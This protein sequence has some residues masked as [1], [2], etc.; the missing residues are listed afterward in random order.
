MMR[1]CAIYSAGPSLR[2]TL[3]PGLSETYETV[4]G[5]NFGAIYATQM[6]ERVDWLCAIDL[7]LID[8]QALLFG[9]QLMPMTGILTGQKGTA[10]YQDGIHHLPLDVDLVFAEALSNRSQH[11]RVVYSV[12]WALILAESLGYQHVDCYG[13][14]QSGDRYAIGDA[15]PTTTWEKQRRIMREVADRQ[16]ANGFTHALI[17]PPSSEDMP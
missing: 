7:Q 17:H 4:I 13:F 11:P 12:N 2:E 6:H 3:R 8:D 5:V 14:D 10:Y 1:G 16:L 9:V 15:Q